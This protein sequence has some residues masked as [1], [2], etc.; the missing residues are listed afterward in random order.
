MARPIQF[1][2]RSDDV[3]PEKL[4]RLL[5]DEEYLTG[6]LRRLGGADAQLVSRTADDETAT[7]VLRHG[8]SEGDL[9]SA[10]RALAPNGIIID[11][12]ETWTRVGDQRYEGVVI[13]Q[14]QGAKVR[15]EG[16][17]LIEEHGI[18]AQMLGTGTVTA[19]IPLMGGMVEGL[20]AEQVGKLLDAESR[21]TLDVI[22][23]RPTD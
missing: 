17:M 3:K 11:R 20:V 19:K 9:P 2:V 5:V 7:V 12:T 14:M 21:F 16:R 8:I 22:A 18:G 1:S 10:V 4:Y 15:I 23:G 6:R 13:A